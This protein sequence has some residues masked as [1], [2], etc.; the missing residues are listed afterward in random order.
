MKDSQSTDRVK[1]IVVDSEIFFAPASSFND[2]FE[3]CPP[4]SFDATPEQWRAEA[5]IQITR[6]EPHLKGSA[7]EKKVSDYAAFMGNPE[8]RKKFEVDMALASAQTHTSQVGVCCLTR[9]PD[10]LLVWAHYADSHAGVCLEFDSSCPFIEDAQEVV[11]SA[12]RAPVNIITDNEKQQTDKMLLTKSDHWA[13]EG[14]WRAIR[15]T[16]GPG[17][18]SFL[19]QHLTGI[20]LGAR[21]TAETEEMVRGWLT[22]RATPCTLYKA[23]VSSTHFE[24]IIEPVS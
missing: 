14:E 1:Q 16:A 10:N 11:Y 9:Q 21:A 3:L 13:Y 7:L 4:F 20:V 24:L 19:P 17:S 12:E 23:T 5:L 6:V 15:Y 2:P 22:A 8:A 18:V